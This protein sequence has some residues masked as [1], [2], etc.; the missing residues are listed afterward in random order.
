MMANVKLDDKMVEEALKLGKFKTKERWTP[1][2][3]PRSAENKMDSEVCCHFYF[4]LSVIHSALQNPFEKR[5]R[6]VPGTA[7]PPSPFS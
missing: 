6:A 4:C 7:R 3:R 1:S 2:F 5:E